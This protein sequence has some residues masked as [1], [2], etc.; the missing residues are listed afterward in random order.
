MSQRAIEVGGHR[1]TVSK[2]DKELFPGEGIDKAAAVDYFHTVA[3]AMLP[4]LKGRP[5]TLRRFPDGIGKNGFFQQEASD[6]FPDWIRTADVPQRGERGQ[7]RH[8]VCQNEATLLY[9]VNQACLE[10][11]VWLSTVDRLEYPNWVVIDLDPAEGVTVGELRE[12]ARG[13][14]ELFTELG[15]VPYVQATGGRGYHVVAPLDGEADYEVVRALAR[16]LTDHLAVEHPDRLTTEQRKDHRGRRIFLDTTRNA[17]GQTV[18]CPYSLR[19]REHAPAA[20]PLDW[21]ELGGTAPD[22]YRLD[23]LPKRLA[24]KRDPWSRISADSRSAE[25]ARHHLNALR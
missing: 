3:A 10:F 18:I 21:S 9:L 25:E 13:L 7:V 15:L 24:Q 4:H 5:L 1:I 19:A 23:S 17:Y 16:G 20:A 8:V 6:Y 14:R 2:A 22:H 11:H 12:T